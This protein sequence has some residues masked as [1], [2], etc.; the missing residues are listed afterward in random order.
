MLDEPVAIARPYSNAGRRQPGH[1]VQ[2][3]NSGTT[4]YHPDGGRVRVKKQAENQTP[5]LQE[6][7]EHLG[8][9]RKRNIFRH[10]LYAHLFLDYVNSLNEFQ[11]L[12]VFLTLIRFVNIK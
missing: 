3:H 10:N 5:V 8:N 2:E 7:Q 11:K 1:V 12:R 6:A 4:I 9:K